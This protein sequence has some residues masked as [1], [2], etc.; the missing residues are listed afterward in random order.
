MLFNS[1]QFLVFFFA[2]TAAYYA[3]PHRGRWPMLLVASCYFYM[4]LIP[5][6]ILILVF[7]ILVDYSAGLLLERTEG[8]PRKAV[9]AGSLLANAGMLGI[10]KYF[11]FVNTNLHGLF[12]LAGLPYNVANLELA[13]PIGLSFHTFQ[14]MSYT[15][16]VYRGRY[17]AEHHL[18]IFAQYVLFY[19]QMVAGPIERPHGLLRQLHVP[20]TFDARGAADGLKLM[21]WGLFKKAV[22]AD[23]LA[24]F[25]NEAYGD[26]SRHAGF[27]LILATYFFA[28]Q[29]Y[30]DF[31]GYS[32][33]AIGA[34]KVMGI[35]LTQNFDR[36]YHA[37]SIGEFW[38]RWHMSLS[39]WFRDYLFL[40]VAY[41]AGRRFGDRT[42][43]GLR[44]RQDVMSYAAGTMVTTLIVGLWHGANWN[45]L[46]WGALHGVYLTASRLTS[47]VRRRAVRA[48]GLD[49]HP[50]VHRALRVGV[51]FH[52]VTFSWIFFRA[53]S[54]EG[55]WSVLANLL[56][57]SLVPVLP[58]SGLGGGELLVALLALALLEVVHVLGERRPMIQ[59]IALL[60]AWT[61]WAL[62]G[63]AV[64]GI[65]LFGKFTSTDFI[66]FQF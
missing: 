41:A 58:E 43:W 36:P 48:A 31:S 42:L 6:Y 63:G 10:F 60:P 40:P 57:G 64:I 23:R 44:V 5:E 56:H 66:Y 25:V 34:A 8:M 30:C 61:R 32:D 51:V 53:G 27:P 21:V 26:P 54:F 28:F 62:Y 29:I 14:S 52:L 7:L 47:G 4:V 1:F 9:F 39:T 33:I 65:L 16:E 13:L 50:R 59:R 17:P 2:V 11:D 55:V 49:R 45:F 12:Q 3:L 37:A 38:R 15:I 20:R 19:P 18:G 24:L 22:I 46:L 35:R